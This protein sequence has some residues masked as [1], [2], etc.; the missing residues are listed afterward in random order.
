MLPMCCVPYTVG[1]QLYILTSRLDKGTNTSRLFESVL[2][3]LSGGMFVAA[4]F[5]AVKS[6]NMCVRAN[7]CV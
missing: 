3:S 1:P 6:E 2:W 7:L 4:G 5:F